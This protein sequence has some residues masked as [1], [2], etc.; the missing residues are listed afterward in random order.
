MRKMLEDIMRRGT[1][2]LGRDVP[3]ER[4]INRLAARSDEEYWMFERMDEERRQKENYRSRLMED[5][6][7]VVY[8]DTISE[9][10][11][12]KAVETGEDSSKHTTR[13]KKTGHL[14]P[15]TSDLIY[16]SAK[17]EKKV[18]ELKSKPEIVPSELTNE[19]S[20]IK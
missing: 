3:S 15:V 4:E 19:K 17:D 5:H 10:Q 13:G 16:N 7:E 2:S 9:L 6:E 1:S 11:W 20:S 12:M 14:P 18:L 8:A